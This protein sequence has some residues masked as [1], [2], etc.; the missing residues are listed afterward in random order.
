MDDNDFEESRDTNDRED[1]H[2]TL[3]ASFST[4]F[5]GNYA[6]SPQACTMMAY[7]R[8]SRDPQV[9]RLKYPHRGDIAKSPTVI[10]PTL[11]T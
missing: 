9:T 5:N 7:K 4:H 3:G 2:C 10:Q 6:Y 8:G 11:V 1:V